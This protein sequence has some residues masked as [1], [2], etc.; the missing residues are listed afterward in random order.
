MWWKGLHTDHCELSD[1]HQLFTAASEH[2]SLCTFCE[3]KK[4]V[5]T[6]QNLA[7]NH[8]LPVSDQ[9]LPFVV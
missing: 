1:W 9:V 3:R 8:V 2:G 4:D 7:R 6:P 5:G